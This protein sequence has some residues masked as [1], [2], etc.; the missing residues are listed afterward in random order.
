M[1][2][3]PPFKIIIVSSTTKLAELALEILK[4]AD[5]S[6]EFLLLQSLTEFRALSPEFLKSS[7]LI[8]FMSK[9][10]LPKGVL[11]TL[12]YKAYNF[13]PGPPQYPGWAPFSFALYDRAQSY[14]ITVHE[15]LEAVDTGPIIAYQEFPIPVDMVQVDLESTTLEACLETL[16]RLA[17]VFCNPKPILS[18][19][20]TWG[21]NRTYQ[22]DFQNMCVIDPEISRE[23][24]HLRLRSFGNG[25]G[26]HFL[27]LTVA[28][29]RY[30][31]NLQQPQEEIADYY[32]LHGVRFARVK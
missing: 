20:T 30:Q 5:P 26:M 24:F 4:K 2:N 3:A 17:K 28:G 15:M 25:D 29:Q 32:L 22:K 18:L 10:I 8:S 13:H 31:L 6:M 9:I 16:K 7:R 11:D 14:G 1:E 27:N 23:E 21:Q 19:A 12:G